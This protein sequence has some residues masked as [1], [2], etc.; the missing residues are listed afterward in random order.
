LARIRF[1]EGS[2][3]EKFMLHD[4]A[5]CLFI[6]QNGKDCAV[7]HSAHTGEIPVCFKATED[8]TYSLVV[9]TENVEMEYLHLIDNMTGADID[10]LQTQSYSFEA[11]TTDNVSRF[12]LA[13]RT[14]TSENT[15][16]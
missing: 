2:D 6:P 8:G 15:E 1:S 10:L 7:V 4:D 14:S 9:N 3:L 11:Q 5:T 13:F 12:R 16:K